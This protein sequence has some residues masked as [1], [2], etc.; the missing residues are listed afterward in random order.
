MC[1]S[2]AGA[3]D[4]QVSTATIRGTVSDATGV[5]PGASVLARNI[6]SGFTHE[7]TTAPDGTFTLAGLR[8]GRFEI[9]VSIGQYAPQAKT[10]EVLV[11]QTVTVDF[12]SRRTS[13]M[14]SR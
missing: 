11:G 8:P 14:Q 5:L 10:V 6:Q 4:A 1:I 9:T 7:A 12:V 13:S 3:A 2:L